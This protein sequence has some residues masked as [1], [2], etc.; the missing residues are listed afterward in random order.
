MAFD[1]QID[2]P[3]QKMDRETLASSK[4]D[5]LSINKRNISMHMIVSEGPIQFYHHTPGS[6]SLL[7]FERELICKIDDGCIRKDNLVS[8]VRGM[9]HLD[10][11]R[12]WNIGR[13]P[14]VQVCNLAAGRLP[15]PL[16]PGLIKVP[17]TNSHCCN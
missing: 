6:D 10:T 16:G 13:W 11:R 2:R 12:R 7:G 8:T 4:A 17:T 14:E 1:K 9:H 15:C 3:S 5:V